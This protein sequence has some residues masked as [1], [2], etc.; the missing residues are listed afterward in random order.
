MRKN[1]QAMNKSAIG[2]LVDTIEGLLERTVDGGGTV[3]GNE[4]NARDSE[5]KRC[6]RGNEMT[7]MVRVGNMKRE[8]Y[9]MGGAEKGL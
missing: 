7:E 1:I 3:Q 8:G 4:E 6:R 5:V 2:E 9:G